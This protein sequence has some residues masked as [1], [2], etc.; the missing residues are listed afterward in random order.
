MLIVYSLKIS[1]QFREIVQESSVETFTTPI[2]F[3][4]SLRI[5]T[6]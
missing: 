1:V 3:I 5:P 2:V 4:H 6:N